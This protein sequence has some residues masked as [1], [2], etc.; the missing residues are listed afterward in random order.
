MQIYSDLNIRICGKEEGGDVSK[1]LNKL[2]TKNF[3]QNHTLEYLAA[4]ISIFLSYPPPMT[5]DTGIPRLIQFLTTSSS[6]RHNPSSVRS[7]F[8]KT[9]NVFVLQIL[10]NIE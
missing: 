9:I 2:L 6:L 8:P 1:I 10:I 4:N 3:L 5:V 7:N